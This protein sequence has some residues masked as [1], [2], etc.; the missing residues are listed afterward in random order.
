MHRTGSSPASGDTLRLYGRERGDG[1]ILVIA[2][3]ALG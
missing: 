2:R 3:A 1:D